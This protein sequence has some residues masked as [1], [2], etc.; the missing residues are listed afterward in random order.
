MLLGTR[1]TSPYRSTGL[2]GPGARAL[3]GIEY[4]SA[5]IASIAARALKDPASLS[6]SE[7]RAIAG[8][9]LTQTRD[10]P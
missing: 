8:S 2:L 9:A 10:Q 1:N 6:S 3:L 7:I 5:E 4:T